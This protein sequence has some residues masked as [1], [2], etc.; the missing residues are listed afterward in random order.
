MNAGTDLALST[1]TH[2]KKPSKHTTDVNVKCKNS[3]FLAGP[4]G[5]HVDDLG[6]GSNFFRYIKAQ[7]LKEVIDILNIKIKK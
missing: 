2:T 6:D 3:K 7:S 4:L 1:Y 5:K